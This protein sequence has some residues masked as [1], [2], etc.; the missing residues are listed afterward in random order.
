[1][2]NVAL[3]YGGNSSEAEVSIKSGKHVSENLDRSKYQVFEIL[4]KEFDWRVQLEG[5]VSIEIDKS[6]FSFLLNG[7]KV[8]FDLAFIM[9]HGTPGEDGLLQAYFEMLG[10]PFNTCSSFVSTISFDKYACKSYLKDSGVRMAKDIFLHRADNYLVEDIVAKL[11]LP[12]FVKPCDGGSSFGIS[13]VKRVEDLVK[14]IDDAF[15][16][17]TT[18]LI[19][20]AIEGREFTEGIFLNGKELVSLPITE[21]IPNNEFFDYE[22]KYLGAS[23]EIC[24]AEISSELE[25]KIK[26]ATIKIYNYFGCKGLVRMDYMVKDNEPYFLEI[27]SVPGMTKMSLVPQQVRAYGLNMKEF[28]S[29]LIDNV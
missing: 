9:I 27:N 14:A 12:L 22:A 3:I 24:P 20:E 26:E 1:M 8:K 10:I 2:K 7:E 23:R 25:S 17:G 6:D 16:E 29:I 13:K 18:V 15:S 11:G 28:F 21:I 4:L 5:G 19:E